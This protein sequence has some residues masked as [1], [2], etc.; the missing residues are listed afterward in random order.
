MLKSALAASVL[1]LGGGSAYAQSVSLTAGPT[2]TTLPDGTSVPMWGY[3]CGAPVAP[4]SCAA[5]NANAAGTWSPV[6]ITVPPGSLTITLTN[7]LP[8]SVAPRGRNPHRSALRARRY[9]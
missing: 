8:A 7:A 3:T 5:L 9:T 1:L 6:L 4:A 2:T